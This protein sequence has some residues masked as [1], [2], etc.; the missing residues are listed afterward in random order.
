MYDTNELYHHGILGQKWGKKNGP[1]YPLDGADHSASEKKAGW[2]KSLSKDSSNE[3]SSGLRFTDKQKKYIKIGAGIVAT[4]A[5]GGVMYRTGM[6][7]KFAQIGAE[8]V[9][10]FNRN[11][12]DI[13][14]KLANNIGEDVSKIYNKAAA[15]Q[16]SKFTRFKVKPKAGTL[17]ENLKVNRG[18]FK[19]GPN[20]PR[21]NNCA[22]STVA[23]LMNEIGLDVKAKPM[24]AEF[25]D[26][27]MTSFEFKR[28]FKGA[29]IYKSYTP[30]TGTVES[31]RKELEGTILQATKRQNGAG[32]FRV[33]G[34]FGGHFMGYKVESGNVF[35]VNPQIESDNVD[36]WLKYIANGTLGGDGKV[37][38]FS[39]LDIL[40]PDIKWIKVACENA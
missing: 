39:R 2:R 32:V 40:P 14:G 12:S 27:G 36:K 24:P 25:V 8:Y 20:D 29:Q 21:R 19:G 26:G 5:I 30:K 22:H 6:Y 4:L 37:D 16:I 38:V 15:N 31:V 7:S 9:S 34:P 35:L 3:D 11:G 23:W 33:P 17:S 10:K 13:P 18:L 28:F 1:P